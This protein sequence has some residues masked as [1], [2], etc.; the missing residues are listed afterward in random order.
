MRIAQITLQ[1][2]VDDLLVASETL[3]ECQQRT[4]DILV[5]LGDLGYG[6]S[7]KKSQLC[8]Q[9]VMLLGYI[10]KQSQCWLSKTLK[11]DYPENLTSRQ[12]VQESGQQGSIDM[13]SQFFIWELWPKEHE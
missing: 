2:Y 5:A 11:R 9:K 7:A 13:D 8:Q 4:E 1:Q 3:E 12:E 10:L 6:A